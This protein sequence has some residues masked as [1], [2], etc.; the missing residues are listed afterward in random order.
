MN[1]GR[2]TFM[3]GFSMGKAWDLARLGS[4]I[5]SDEMVYETKTGER[6]RSQNF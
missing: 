2:T 3:D 1:S 6:M 4:F 5:V